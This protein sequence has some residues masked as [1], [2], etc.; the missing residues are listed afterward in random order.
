MWTALSLIVLLK[1]GVIPPT[2]KLFIRSHFHT[3]YNFKRSPTT[4]ADEVGSKLILTP[5]VKAGNIKEA[6]TL[7]AVSGGPFPDDIPS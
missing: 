2:A 7:S 1:W 4:L 3:N 5:Y 6:R